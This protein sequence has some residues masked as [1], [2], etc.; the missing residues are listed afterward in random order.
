[1]LPSATRKNIIANRGDGKV[2]VAV[3]NFVK[4]GP[5]YF[6]SPRKVGRAVP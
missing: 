4:L 3:L 6:V 2:R 5:S 1:M